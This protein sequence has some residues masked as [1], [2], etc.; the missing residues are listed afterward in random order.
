M[1]FAAFF[2]LDFFRAYYSFCLHPSVSAIAITTLNYAIALYPIFLIGVTFAMVKLYDHNFRPLVWIWKPLG[3]IVKPLR[4]EWD[5]RTSLIDVFASFIYVSSSQIFWV[6]ATLL[7][8]TTTYTYQQTSDEY[9]QLHYLYMFPSV[10]FFSNEHIPFA[11]LASTMLFMF[12]ILPMILLFVY[13]FHWFQQLL[14]RFHFNSIILRIFMDVFQGSYKDGTNGTRDYRYFS[15]LFLFLQLTLTVTYSQTLSFF[16]YSVSSVW[17]LIYL[18]LHAIFQPFKHR[19]HNIITIAMIVTMMLG[20]LFFAIQGSIH[21]WLMTVVFF[22]PFLY[23]FC[24]V[25]VQ[26]K[27]RLC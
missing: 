24:L 25:Y 11:V 5:V 13:P 6:S 12:C 19:G 3:C 4:R 10:Q 1:Y 27:K 9:I 2:N 26:L 21:K 8:P 15:G 16:Y 14:N 17:I 23:L 22:V 20:Y 7:V 18:I